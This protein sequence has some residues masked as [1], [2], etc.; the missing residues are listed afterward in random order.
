MAGH[1]HDASYGLPRAF[2]VGRSTAWPRSPSRGWSESG[3]PRGANETREVPG[4]ALA[5]DYGPVVEM[6]QKV[7]VPARGRVTAD[8]VLDPPR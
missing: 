3:R 4:G 2:R 6:S 8:F 7:T 1:L 5:Y